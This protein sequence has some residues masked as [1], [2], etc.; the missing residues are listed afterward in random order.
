MSTWEFSDGTKFH[1]GGDVEGETPFAKR[2]RQGAEDA[3]DGHGPAVFVDPMPCAPTPVDMSDPQLVNR[4]VS[5]IARCKGI[6]IASAPFV[7]LFEGPAPRT[8]HAADVLY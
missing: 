7:P 3:R 8:S 4:W 2:L 1:L 6:A 5:N